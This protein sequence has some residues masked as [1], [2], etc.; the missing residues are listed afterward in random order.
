MVYVLTI[1]KIMGQIAYTVVRHPMETTVIER[2]HGS[3]F[4][5]FGS[6]QEYIDCGITFPYDNYI[7]IGG[8]RGRTTPSRPS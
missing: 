7:V 8:F 5:R 3:I 1:L 6:R 2:E 4:K